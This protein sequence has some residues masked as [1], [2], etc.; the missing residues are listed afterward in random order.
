IRQIQREPAQLLN[1]H[2]ERHARAQRRFLEDHGQRLALQRAMMR[3]GMTLDLARQIQQV[4]YFFRR[5][6]LDGKEIMTAHGSTSAPPVL[7][8]VSLAPPVSPAINP[9]ELWE[10]PLMKP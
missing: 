1:A 6:I 2:V 4:T 8:G 10:Q 9:Q 5:E 7:P 3:R